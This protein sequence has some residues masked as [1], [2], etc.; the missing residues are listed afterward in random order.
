M[1]VIK[2]KLVLEDG[3]VWEGLSRGAGVETWGEV[4]FNTSMTGYQEILTDPSY[5]GQIV[6]MTFPMI[7]NY[8]INKEDS[9]SRRPFLRGFIARE[10][11]SKPHNWRSVMTVEEYLQ[12]NNITALEGIDTR[13]LTRHLREKGTM[14][15]IITTADSSPAELQEKIKQLPTISQMDLISEVTIPEVY[16]WGNGSDSSAPHIVILDLGLKTPI[17]E[18]LYKVGC[19]VTIVPASFTAAEIMELKP[20]GL[21]LSNGPGDPQA[22]PG[23]IKTVQELAGKI[24]IMGICLGHQ[25]SALALGANT[26]KLKFGHRGAN[27]PVKDLLRDRVYITSQNHG[28]AVCEED[29]PAGLEVTHRN[30]NDGTIEGL[31]HKKMQ[32]YTI[33][34]HPEAFPGPMDSTYIFDLFLDQVRN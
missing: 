28:F 10:F 3:S 30:I 17:A 32:M 24:P 18:S 21:M 11:C 16:T 14:R 6:A 5:C 2:A 22:A 13:A 15:G 29:L 20:G 4:V 7:G 33:Q 34:Y 19:R 23:A 27:H 8:G 26:Y 25:V 1:R 12:E 9:Q 31:Q